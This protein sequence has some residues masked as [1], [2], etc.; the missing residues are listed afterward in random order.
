M[1][2]DTKIGKN[3]AVL[4]TFVRGHLAHAAAADN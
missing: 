3:F 4:A 2:G 1:A